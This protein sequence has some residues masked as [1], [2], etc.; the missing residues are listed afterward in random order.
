MVK[1]IDYDE[2]GN[3]RVTRVFNGEIKE[4]KIYRKED[5]EVISEEDFEIPIKRISLKNSTK[6]EI[7]DLFDSLIEEDL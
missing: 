5:I 4:E 2:Q 6:S 1:V 7:K 3:V